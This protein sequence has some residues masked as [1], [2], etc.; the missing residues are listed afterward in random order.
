MK[1]R[2]NDI[3]KI[4]TKGDAI[5]LFRTM[6]EDYSLLFMHLGKELGYSRQQTYEWPE[7][8]PEKVRNQ[9]IGFLV[10]ENEKQGE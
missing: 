7:I 2:N 9:M 3:L 5:A 6:K 8:L 10:Q 4:T 1:I